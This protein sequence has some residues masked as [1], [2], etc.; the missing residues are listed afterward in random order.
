MAK[1]PIQEIVDLPLTGIRFSLSDKLLRAN[2]MDRFQPIH[3]GQIEHLAEHMD[4]AESDS[5]RVNINQLFNFKVKAEEVR[6]MMMAGKAIGDPLWELIESLRIIQAEKDC[7]PA[8]VAHL[9]ETIRD[10]QGCSFSS[11]ELK[12]VLQ[13]IRDLSGERRLDAEIHNA[14]Q[15]IF[16]GKAP[17][18]INLSSPA[19]QLIWA[20][21]LLFLIY[22]PWLM[23][24][25]PED[26]RQGSFSLERTKLWKQLLDSHHIRYIRVLFASHIYNLLRNDKIMVGWGAPGSWFS[27]SVNPAPGRINCDLLYAMLL[28]FDHARAC[29]VHEIGHAVQTRGIPHYIQ[30]LSDAATEMEGDPEGDSL[31]E[32]L[33]LKQYF[34]NASEDNCINRYT[35]EIGGVFGQN[36]GYSLNYFYTAIGDIG[37]RY[38]R[39]QPFYDESSPQNRFKN[40][41]FIISRA[42]L[43]HNGLFENTEEDWQSVMARPEWIK[44][45]DRRNPEEF[46]DEERSFG[47]LM[48]MC[49]EIEHYFPPLQEMA[50]GADHYGDLAGTYAEKRFELIH[51]MWE[52]Y[53]QD[54][55]DEIIERDDGD[56]DDS[57]DQFQMK[58][59]HQEPPPKKKEKKEEKEKS[60][61]ENK[62]DAEEE[63]K[64]ENPAPPTQSDNDSDKSSDE[65]LEGD[66]P[67]QEKPPE[68]DDDSEGESGEDASSGDGGTDDEPDDTDESSDEGDPE[69]GEDDADSASEPDDGGK[70]ASDQPKP[71]PEKPK[72]DQEIPEDAEREEVEME[73]EPPEGAETKDE[74]DPDQPTED[75]PDQPQEEEPPTELSA[76]ELEEMMQK[77]QDQL[78]DMVEYKE[79][80]ESDIRAEEDDEAEAELVKEEEDKTLEPEQK[81]AEEK[82]DNQD[83]GERGDEQG[84]MPDSKGVLDRA[85]LP[86]DPM[87]SIGDLMEALRETE[88]LEQNKPERRKPERNDEEPPPRPKLDIPPPMSLDQLA[89]GDWQDF[90]RRV[91]LHGPVI[92]MMAKALEKLKDAQLKLIHKISKKHSI[93]PQGG[94]LRRFD[95]GAMHRLLQQIAKNEAFNKDDLA[96]FRKDDRRAAPT[97][98]TRII[99]I[100]GSRSMTFGSSPFPMDKAIQEAVIDYMASRIAG[101]D[102]YITMFGPLNP[103]TLAQPGDSLVEIGK[104]IEK[105]HGGLNTM[106]YLAP[107]LMQTIQQ[108]ANRKKFTEPYMGFTN[109]VI[110]SDGDIDD[111]RNSREVIQQIFLHA[112]KTTFDFVLI[113][114]KH[115]TPMDVLI[116]T[117]DLSSPIHDIGV[118]RSNAQRHY[119]LALTSTYKLTTRIRAAKSGF[120]DPSWF[121]GAQFKRLLAHLTR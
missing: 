101:Y 92:A 120:A 14:Y 83:S 42:F 106:T 26:R 118:V 24:A 65:D 73:G 2:S 50:G 33:K 16:T 68:E 52:L 1:N 115:A 47:Q 40:L 41:T 95:H 27:F 55:V 11:M 119:P 43:T 88:K 4:A 84:G 21:H 36:Y 46:L 121:R 10:W 82:P 93:I 97:R 94:D 107:A 29:I 35:T 71:P 117:L 32:E 98:P 114:N 77:L 6:E 105:V 51:E 81:S 25:W 8:L 48:E 34:L 61:E 62:D 19:R 69:E 5:Y 70:G 109:F 112:P 104:R 80:E 23:Q 108:V 59:N 89:T 111:T 17:D 67:D 66:Q 72:D 110:Y 39:R 76:E 31:Q 38:V 96:M 37:R 44:G 15:A 30:D 28:G 103:I 91:S 63:K 49:E 79:N 90:S 13:Q 113:T 100:D 53:A 12:F 60:E 78:N 57:M 56:V 64:E 20:T 85:H 87:A 116:R 3:P 22:N 74:K 9:E 45:R 99:L 75:N 7:P 54:I 18:D 58:M 86:D 102:T